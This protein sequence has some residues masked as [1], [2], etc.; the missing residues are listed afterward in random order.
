MEIMEDTIESKIQHLD[1][2][3]VNILEE[4]LKLAKQMSQSGII[5]END[6]QIKLEG[7]ATTLILNSIF[8]EFEK[9]IKKLNIKSIV[10]SGPVI[11]HNGKLLVD[12]DLK[13]DFYKIPGGTIS[14]GTEDLEEACHRK[15][16][17]GIN[18]EIEIIKPLHPKVLWENPQTKEKMAILLVSYLAKLKNPKEIRPI[19]PI[20][21]V[22][23]LDLKD[24]DKWKDQVS[25]YTQFL[26]EKGDIK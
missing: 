7:K 25:P 22:K 23:W 21:E 15:A 17:E 26:I 16:R 18:A 3:L 19:E 1:N 8:K 5:N 6:F 10:A 12:K 13:D 20:Q 2:Q 14:P 11:I 4:R 24:V 9:R